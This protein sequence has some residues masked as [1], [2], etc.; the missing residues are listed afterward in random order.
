MRALGDSPAATTRSRF[1]R[2]GT[3]L[4]TSSRLTAERER[5]DSCSSITPPQDMSLLQQREPLSQREV[6]RTT[7]IVGTLEYMAPEVMIMFG[8]KRLHKDGYSGAIDF[9]SLGILIHRLLIGS[10]P[11]KGYSYER[12][13]EILP[14]HLELDPNFETAFHVL[15]GELNLDH[16]HWVTDNSRDIITKLLVFEADNRLGY[17]KNEVQIGHTALM[18][19]PFF[20][21][22]DWALLELKQIIPPY[23]PSETET[24]DVLSEHNRPTKPLNIIDILTEADHGNWCDEFIP[25]VETFAALTTTRYRIA[26]NKEDQHYFRMWNYVNPKLLELP[27]S[28]RSRA[29]SIG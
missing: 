1:S 20:Q 2:F 24:L 27:H 4:F 9:W 7:S 6:P 11:Y 23:I 21:G 28:Q 15:F 5:K 29:V 3:A 17:D 18:N 22:L 14:A 19:H 8:N 10:D 25:R 13:Q 16:Y 12:I 26:I